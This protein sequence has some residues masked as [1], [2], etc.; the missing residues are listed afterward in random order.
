MYQLTHSAD[1]SGNKIPLL[2]REHSDYFC[3]D[4][5]RENDQGREKNRAIYRKHRENINICAQI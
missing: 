5:E 2:L 4:F 3:F 1:S